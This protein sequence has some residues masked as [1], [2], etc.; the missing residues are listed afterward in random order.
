MPLQ[1]L[2]ARRPPVSVRHRLRLDDMLPI[3]AQLDDVGCGSALE[4]W[5]APASAFSAASHVG[6]LREL[7]RPC[8]TPLQ[9]LLRAARAPA[10][11]PPL[12]H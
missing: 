4:C 3:A 5:A 2:S 1:M 12:R 9:M 11:L 6:R 7:K 10:R 8:R